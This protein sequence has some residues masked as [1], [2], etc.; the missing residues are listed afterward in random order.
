MDEEVGWPEV[1]VGAVEEGRGRRVGRGHGTVAIQS[2][3]EEC[4]PAS[5][6]ALLC[7]SLGLKEGSA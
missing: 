4:M 3:G 5:F 6:D 7:R 2:G 1:A